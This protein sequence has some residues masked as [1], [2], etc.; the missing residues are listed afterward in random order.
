MAVKSAQEFGVLFVGVRTFQQWALAQ[1]QEGL[2]SAHGGPC[3][4]LARTQAP[5]G[6]QAVEPEA[7]HAH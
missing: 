2:L 4:A 1:A 3:A 5:A 7:L 6:L